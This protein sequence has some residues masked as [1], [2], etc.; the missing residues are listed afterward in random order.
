MSS[1]NKLKSLKKKYKSFFSTNRDIP[2][3]V[4]EPANSVEGI[5]PSLKEA[6]FESSLA[7]IYPVLR[8]IMDTN[9]QQKLN[10]AK[11]MID[12]SGYKMH[13]K[14]IQKQNTHY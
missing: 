10:K 12:R 4:P 14:N 5:N 13:N 6:E 11:D 7:R 1:D 2:E 3:P 8:V 9:M